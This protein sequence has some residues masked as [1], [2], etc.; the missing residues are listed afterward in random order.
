MKSYH[1]LST[2]LTNER[3]TEDVMLRMIQYEMTTRQRATVLE[4][5]FARYF[6]VRKNVTII[7]AQAWM[8]KHSAPDLFIKGIEI[9]NEK[10]RELGSMDAS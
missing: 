6:R 5:L 4:R 3:F 10:E 2:H 1:H 7:A 9:K 8:K